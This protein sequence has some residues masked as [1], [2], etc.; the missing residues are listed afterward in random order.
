MKSKILSGMA[1]LF[2]V[3]LFF[4]S[5][6]KIEEPFTKP[7]VVDTTTT[8]TVLLEDYTGHRCVNCPEAAVLSGNLKQNMGDNLVIIAVHAGFFAGLLPGEGF[9]VDYTTEEG[10][11][12]NAD[13]GVESY[14]IGMVNRMGFSTGEHLLSIG[15][16]SKEV[17][18]ALKEPALLDLTV[19][20][21]YNS[22]TR[23][24]TATVE[25]E[26][27]Q[28]VDKNLKLVVVL[29][30]SGMVSQQKNNN[31]EV[32]PTPLIT[33]YVHKHVMRG[34]ING[35]WGTTITELGSVPQDAISKSFNY[36]IP[37]NFVAEN[38]GVVAFVYDADTKEVLEAGEAEVLE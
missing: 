35:T 5:C 27:L 12:W 7:L 2:T 23:A 22:T 18:D 17:L 36:V 13:F 26:F 1:M 16:W 11:T 31:A 9:T 32:G 4:V 20:T 30:E 3:S 14:P 38:C 37:D 28:V 19:T 10:N 6:D 29:T 34:C 25:T 21:G 8:K 24:L 33:D 15:A